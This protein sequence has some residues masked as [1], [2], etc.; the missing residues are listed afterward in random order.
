MWFGAFT[1]GRMRS[2]LGVF[3]DGTGIARYSSVET[4]PDYRGRGLASTLVYR[5]GRQRARNF[6]VRMLVIVADPGE[7]AIRI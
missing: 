6:N 5:T 2:G 7:A 3:T 1:D 4:H